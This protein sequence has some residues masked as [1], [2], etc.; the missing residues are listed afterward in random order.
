MR[1]LSLVAAPAAL[2]LLAACSQT[3][4]GAAESEP[5]ETVDVEAPNDSAASGTRSLAVEAPTVSLAEGNLIEALAYL[6][7]NGARDGVT[8][9]ASGLQYEVVRSGPADGQSPALGQ[10]VCVHYRGAFLDGTEFDSSYSR[11]QAAAFPSDQLISGWVE[12]LQMMKPG[13]AWKLH[14]HPDIAYGA[15]GR[16]G[17]PPN[18]ALVFDIELIELLDGPVARGV[19][20][21]AD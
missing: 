17:I 20:C 11:G 7:E 2:L 18:A 19:D 1:I 5:V 6:A 14:I 13:D 12:S 10:F 15:E 8:T 9:T 4:E 21:A 3:V 16:S